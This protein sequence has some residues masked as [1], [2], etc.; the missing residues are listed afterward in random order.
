MDPRHGKWPDD[1]YGLCPEVM[2]AVDEETY[3]RYFVGSGSIMFYSNIKGFPAQDL[4]DYGT[5]E[6]VLG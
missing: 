2:L 6:G 3:A 4:P 1:L 5:P